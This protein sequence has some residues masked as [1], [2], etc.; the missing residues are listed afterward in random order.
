[1]TGIEVSVLS[2][3]VLLALILHF[4][5]HRIKIYSHKHNS[6]S[7]LKFDKKTSDLRHMDE[8]LLHFQKCIV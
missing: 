1:M 6:Y 5:C 3:L 8:M 4:R 2:L 7:V